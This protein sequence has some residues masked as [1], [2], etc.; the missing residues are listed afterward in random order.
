MF[1]RRTVTMPLN[2]CHHHCRHHGLYVPN[3]LAL[4]DFLHEPQNDLSSK[5]VHAPCQ[6]DLVLPSRFILKAPHGR[7]E[8]PEPGI[9][10]WCHNACAYHAPRTMVCLHNAEGNHAK[11]LSQLT[12]T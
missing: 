10:Q 8:N 12:R 9:L 6:P 3:C 1:P 5:E 4:L 2:P 7:I 11:G